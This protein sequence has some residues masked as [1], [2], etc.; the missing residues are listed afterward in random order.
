MQMQ[1]IRVSRIERDVHR[2]RIS[3]GTRSKI[4]KRLGGNRAPFLCIFFP[5][6]VMQPICSDLRPQFGQVFSKGANTLKKPTRIA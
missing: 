1:Q 6:I 3:H 4:R 5:V 2:W